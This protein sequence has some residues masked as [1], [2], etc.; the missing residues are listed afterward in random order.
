M[1]AVETSPLPDAQT[2]SQGIALRRGL[3]MLG[4]TLIVPGSAQLAGG[5]ERLGRVALRVWATLIVLAVLFGVLFLTFRS[6]A[7]GLYANTLTLQVL[8]WA[9]LVLGLGWV[10]LFVNAWR[11]ANPPALGPRGKV[12]LPVIAFV[13]A[14]GVGFSSWTLAGAFDAQSRLFGNVFTGGGKAETNGGR[15]NVL[16]LGGDA[17]A[18]REGL[19][20][21]T[22]IVASIDANTGRTVLF[23]LPRNLQHA[24]FPDSSPL[25]KLYPD[26]YWCKDQSCLLNAVYTLATNHKNLYP[27]VKNPGVQATKEVIENILGLQIN[28]WALVDLKGFQALIDAVGGIN[29]DVAR[30]VPI[31]GGTNLTTGKKYPI[32][33]W[34]GPGKNLHLD[35]HRALWFARSREGSTDYER[36][37]RQKCVLNAMVKQLNPVTV[38]TKFQE[39]AKAGEEI[40]ATDLPT[41]QIGT[42]LDL[43]QRGRSLPLSSVSFAPPL[44]RPVKPDFAKIREV[45]KAKI[46]ASEAAGDKPAKTTSSAPTP[47]G[48]TSASS[49]PKPSTSS[50]QVKTQTDDLDEVCTVS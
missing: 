27:G 34:I 8:R 13:L 24:P 38:I 33:G 49:S 44:I 6:F 22:M 10:L 31:G 26:G 28:Y 11:I 21:D 3:A 17:G 9:S 48:G 39:I 36:M 42:M 23:S 7:I 4:M 20:P 1:T 19:R 16:L 18:D 45:V 14:L 46:A 5:N 25:K 30:K 35:G 12:A 50:T 43:A 32:T 47:S 2:R 41:S 15:Y 37:A 40:V 29:L